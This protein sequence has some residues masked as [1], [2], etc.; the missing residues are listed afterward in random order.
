MG[1]RCIDVTDCIPEGERRGSCNR[2]G[3]VFLLES[4]P[5]RLCVLRVGRVST[6]YLDSRRGLSPPLRLQVEGELPLL[7][8]VGSAV[9][10]SESTQPGTAA[11]QAEVAAQVTK[12][13]V[14]LDL[15]PFLAT[16]NGVT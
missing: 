9:L 6:Q 14:G 2:C 16:H 13:R 8:E 12:L 4:F 3:F 11:V 10:H 7:V 5:R 15:L 1:E